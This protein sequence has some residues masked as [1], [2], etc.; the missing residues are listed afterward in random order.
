[1]AR[2]PIPGGDDGAWGD[3]LNGYLSIA[4]NDDGTLKSIDPVKVG[5]ENVNNTSDANKPISTATQTALNLKADL[6]GG[7]VPSAQIPYVLPQ[8][9]YLERPDSVGFQN[10]QMFK[11]EATGKLLGI[12]NIAL[13]G[14]YGDARD[15]TG[16]PCSLDRPLLPP[17]FST[18]RGFIT[19][20][21]DDG[22]TSLTTGTWA[23][24]DN[25]TPLGYAASKK[26]PLTFALVGNSQAAWAGIKAHVD[27][28]G[29]EIGNHSMTHATK[30]AGVDDYD[31]WYSEVIQAKAD[32]EAYHLYPAFSHY[33]NG[34]S[35]FTADPTTGVGQFIRLSHVTMR[36]T[37]SVSPNV[38][39]IPPVSRRYSLIA[40]KHTGVDTSANR[41]IAMRRVV[42]Y[43]RNSNGIYL[44]FMGHGV[45]ADGDG[46]NWA[47]LE[48]KE[49]VDQCAVGIEAGDLEVLPS[50]QVMS[51]YPIGYVPNLIANPG[52]EY[53]DTVYT[54]D[55]KFSMA[56]FNCNSEDR[57]INTNM[58]STDSAVSIDSSEH[59][60]GSK[61]LK[62]YRPNSDGDC[63]T[64]WYRLGVVPG[65][66]Y[67][68]GLWYKSAG[69]GVNIQI[70]TYANDSTQHLSAWIG[71]PAAADWTYYWRYFTM[72][73]DVSI[74]RVYIKAAS[75][76]TAYVDDVFFG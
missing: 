58:T 65:Q 41:V 60:S 8:T 15:T 18:A 3:I 51:T 74:A 1:M 39:A 68:F 48:F 42:N 54:A 14:D 43:L 30:G 76:A 59:H 67:K 49:M 23:Q 45:T 64:V 26:V 69:A 21:A 38:L 53:E 33:H 9:L 25:K 40:R 4:H 7:K 57:I 10:R 20:V 73:T 13:G 35:F 50:Y 37:T 2:L 71:L 6:T 19:L 55:D 24:L 56:F 11:T 27:A 72:G 17:R 44:Q 34:S 5:L 52:F 12:D 32:I 28:C 47:V 31:Y 70:I 46:N 61:S 63:Y 36:Q 29:G 16:V 75:G 62:L 22:A 66:Q